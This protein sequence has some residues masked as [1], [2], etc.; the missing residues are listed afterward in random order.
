MLDEIPVEVFR[1]VW[2]SLLT[3]LLIFERLDSWHLLQ[4]RANSLLYQNMLQY[5]L[6]NI[7]ESSKKKVG[8]I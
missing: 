3:F 6:F 1:V 2:N 4:D 5:S 8:R 7:R